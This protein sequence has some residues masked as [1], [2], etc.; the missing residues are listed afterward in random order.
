[1]HAYAGTRPSLPG[2][3]VERAMTAR[4]AASIDAWPL[5]SQ[6]PRAEKGHAPPWL[7]SGCAAPLGSAEEAK[8]TASLLGL[9][10][11]RRRRRLDVVAAAGAVAILRLV[12]PLGQLEEN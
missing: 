12:N 8:E 11:R 3:C 4:S 6:R 10:R 9:R 5:Q 1:M 7:A 2:A